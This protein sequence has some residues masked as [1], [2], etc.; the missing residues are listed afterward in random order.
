MSIGD[1]VKNACQE[2]VDETV[3]EMKP[4]FDEFDRA[5]KEGEAEAR[6]ERG[7]PDFDAEQIQSV[8]DA[9]SGADRRART[10]GAMLRLRRWIEEHKDILKSTL[11]G[12]LSM[13]PLEDRAIVVL[14]DGAKKT[15]GGLWIPESANEENKRDTVGVV[16][17]VG[18]GRILDNGER[19]PMPV[20][21]GDTV[22]FGK[23]TG[24]YLQ[25][26]ATE[27]THKHDFTLVI[28]G[29]RDIQCKILEPDRE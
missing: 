7:E 24:T 18:P 14:F 17:A 19:A 5:L 15:Q 29:V 27:S 2:A 3:A 28:L 22:R 21:P 4:D 12:E 13:Q 23:W 11:D 6:E 1:E 9:M 16:V 8:K 26:T 25:P 10:E 20:G